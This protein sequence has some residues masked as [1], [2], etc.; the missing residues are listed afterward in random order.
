MLNVYNVA[1]VPF[2]CTVWAIQV[3]A[4]VNLALTRQTYGAFVKRVRHVHK[5]ILCACAME[6][7][8]RQKKQRQHLKETKVKQMIKNN[9]IL[10]KAFKANKAKT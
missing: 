6:R 5:P 3:L 9:P 8:E 10:R 1:T 2:Q 7:H 4:D